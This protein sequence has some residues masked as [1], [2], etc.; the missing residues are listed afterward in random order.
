MA[1]HNLIV[2]SDVHLG[3]DLVQHSRP[4]A[5]ERGAAS[6]RRDRELV[7]LL[8]WYWKRP[9][10]GLPWRLVIA[11]DLID[12]AGMSVSAAPD[13]IVTEPN[14]EE[15]R[16]GLGSSVDHT[17]AKLRRVAERHRPVFA[18]IARFVA[19]G[20]TLVVLRGNHD[21]DLHWEPVKTAFRAMLAE[22]APLSAGSVEFADWFYYEEGL[23]YVE[24]GHQYDD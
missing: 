3:S 10:R 16:H 9:R 5:P 15:R 13:E 2:L 7:G 22:H 19:A 24:H 12:F 20:H 8:D 14:D 4:D 11:G 18:A 17:L 21:V 1:P 6:E 23:V